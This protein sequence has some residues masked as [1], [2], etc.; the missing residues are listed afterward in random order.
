M[1]LHHMKFIGHNLYF[2]HPIVMLR[3]V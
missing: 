2:K 3:E 1:I